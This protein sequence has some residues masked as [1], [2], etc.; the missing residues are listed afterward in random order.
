MRFELGDNLT[1][2]IVMIIIAVVFILIIG[3]VP[4]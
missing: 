4:W 1:E 3:G 2:I